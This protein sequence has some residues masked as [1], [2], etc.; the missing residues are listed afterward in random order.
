M[1]NTNT[2]TKRDGRIENFDLE[3][4]HKVL[5]WATN[6]IAG[7]SISEIEL[8]AN[9]QLF[10]KIPAY[11]IHELLIK[12]A[13]EL[14]S[15]LTPNYQ[16]V[17]ARLVNY[18]IRKE[19]YGQFEPWP[20]L[21]IVKE[22]VGRGVYD[23]AILDNYTEQEI[24]QLG[25]YIRHDRDDDFTY[26][27]MEQFRGK[28]LV[29]DRRTKTVFESPQV[30]YMLIA[31][32]L[33]SQYP[34]ETR[35]KWVKDY[36]DDIST[37]GTSL[38]TPIMAGVRTSTRQFSSC[39]LIESDDTLESINATATSV[40][41]YI[42][43]KAGIG[44]NAGRIRAV[45]SR[46]G[47]GS[48]VHTGLIPFLKYF[49][50]AVK[51]C[52]Q[53]GV[54]GGAATVYL[55]IWHLEFEDLV[56]LKNNKGTEENRV[57]QLDYAFQFNKLMYER[58]LTGG[59]ITLFSPGDVPGM[60]DAYFND[61][62]KFRELYEKAERSTKIRKKTMPAIDVFSQFV[63]ER[64]DT[65]RIY[66][67]NVDHANEHGSFLP[68]KA[69]I[70]QSNLCTE[71]TLPTIPLQSADDK[72]GEIS[73][74]TLSA[75]NWGLINDP[76]DFEKPCTLAVRALD[77]LL[78][79]Q[80][81]PIPAA[82][83][84]TMN[85]R[86]LGVGIINLAYFLAKRGLTYGSPESLLVIDEYAEAW[87]YYLIKAS[88][89][90]AKERGACLKSDETKYHSGI[91]PID[92]YKRDVDDLVPH[93]ERMDWDGLRADLKTYGIRNSTLMALMPAETSAQI[94]NST[95]GIEPPRALVSYKAS[96]DGVMAQVVPGYHHL[97]N[98]YD[99][100]WNQKT[101]EG[102]LKVCAV[103]QKYIDQGIS[104]N[105]SYNPEHFD[106]GKV[107]MSQ[108]IKDIVT[109][110]KYGGKQLYYN[111]THDGSG[112]M[113]TED[114]KPELDQVDY[115]EEDCSSCTI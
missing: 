112:E 47:D 91:L 63:T 41:R 115:D 56:V 110:Y 78:D 98:K 93:Q 96:K 48:V 104:V 20:L 66:L 22:N 74:C 99:L 12:S 10:N 82:E 16:Y 38:P 4:I 35:M 24:E 11:D 75:I 17:A 2:V 114:D 9:I 40:V 67:M 57:R 50:S 46:V 107:P 37:F 109:F 42:S 15:E 65:G 102:Y 95:N 83:I 52:S 30:L 45:D 5:D 36:Y 54:R 6:G 49:S 86:P 87:S 27:G 60:Y 28:Y 21:N 100:L 106:E 84:S 32:T 72:E 25:S 44:I 69:T 43:K 85:R 105:T 33:F 81:Y 92:T 14:I 108:L 55:P 19:V 97:K 79:Y 8:R 3:K 18:K 76:K 13:A 7:V 73:L 111:N 39:V 29:Q 88:V 68:D 53:G 61:Q 90:I 101:P 94:S 64:K 113:S 89:D 1:N 103:L 51:S 62:D 26:V 34:S 23:S 70:Y 31:A 71:I 59:N 58:L 80:E 77:A